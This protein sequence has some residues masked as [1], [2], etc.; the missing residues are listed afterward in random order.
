[1]T[2][3]ATQRR[4]LLRTITMFFFFNSIRNAA[5]KVNGAGCHERG[6]V[7]GVT[8]G[9]FR[10]LPRRRRRLRPL[11]TAASRATSPGSPGTGCRRSSTSS[12]SSRAPEQPP[13][14]RRREARY[15]TED[16]R[17]A[18]VRRREGRK[19]YLAEQVDVGVRI[20]PAPKQ[21]ADAMPHRQRQRRQCQRKPKQKCAGEQMMRASAECK[22]QI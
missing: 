15:P 20:A 21:S 14:T 3:G 17:D 8:T 2:L 19:T 9:L 11:T 13:R 10:R 6:D 4:E 7:P 12:S 22:R 18:P 16:E 1:V 5:S